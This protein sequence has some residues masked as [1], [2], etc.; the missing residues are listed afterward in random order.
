MY[1]LVYNPSTNRESL[2]SFNDRL[3]ECCL[4]ENAIQIQPQSV[5]GALVINVWTPGDIENIP[6]GTPTMLASILPLNM[7]DPDIEEQLDKLREREEAKATDEDPI[8]EA[9]NVVVLPN[10]SVSIMGW[11]IV[12]VITGEIDL[13]NSQ[14]EGEEEQEG[15]NENDGGDNDGGSPVFVPEVIPPKRN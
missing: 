9:T 1:T 2:R 11:A 10:H 7:K 3:A 6:D 8:R 15:E 14:Q 4:D 12:L 5:G 13:E